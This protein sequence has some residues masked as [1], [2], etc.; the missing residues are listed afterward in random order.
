M[1]KTANG[2]GSIRHRS[3]GRWEARYAT[4]YDP[5]TG[6]ITYKSIYAKTQKEVKTKLYATI[7][8][9]DS[10][11][12]I[13]PCKTRLADWINT[14]LNEYCADK[15]YLTVKGYKASCNTHIIPAIGHY[16]LCDLNSITIQKFYNNLKSTNGEDLAPKTIKN[17]HTVLR[18]ILEQAK[19]NG[20]IRDN[21]CDNTVIPKVR[22]PEIK[23]LT[24]EQV[25][26]LLTIAEKDEIYGIMFEVTMLTGLRESEAMALSWDCVDFEKGVLNI[27]KQLQHRPQKDGGYTFSTLKNDKGRKIRPAPFVMN[28]LKKQYKTQE[29]QKEISSI[30]WSGWITETQRKKSLVFTTQTGE[31]LKHKNVYKHFKKI[32]E[33]IG[34]PEARVHDLRHTFAVLSLENGDDIKTVQGN[35]GHASAAF[36][37]DVYGHVSDEMQRASSNRME[38][39]IANLRI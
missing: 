31:H 7:A 38:K 23:P 13:E 15:K 4:G 18:T 16:K 3:D 17:I 28:L 19:K 36:T 21:P 39:Y 37:L 33:E 12:Y 34:V 30:L 26:E 27:N 5:K 29:R 24:D 6:K 32:A 14:W 35:L 25:K 20:Y 1:S 8:E 9:I 10:E 11:T 22:K 2:S